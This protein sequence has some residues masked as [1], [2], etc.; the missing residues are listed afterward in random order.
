MICLT[1][2][3]LAF[4][5]S[6]VSFVFASSIVVSTASMSPWASTT[7]SWSASIFSFVIIIY[8][9]TRIFW[10][11][12]L[13]ILYFSLKLKRIF[14]LCGLGLLLGFLSNLWLEHKDEDELS[15]LLKLLLLL[16]ESD[17]LD[18]LDDLNFDI[19]WNYL[20][21]LIFNLK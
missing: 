3:L 19:Y 4:G 2:R 15:D 1:K 20:G 11:Y 10:N 17:E 21:L 18:E 8:F 13:S 6:D 9:F 12:W 5:S 14:Y 16:E 7:L